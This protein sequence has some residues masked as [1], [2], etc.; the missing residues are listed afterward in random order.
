M[1]PFDTQDTE[2]QEMGSPASK[3]SQSLAESPFIILLC[4]TQGQHALQSPTLGPGEYLVPGLK[5]SLA[6]LEHS[7]TSWLP[8]FPGV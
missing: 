7:V 2:A 4:P 5:V 3:A 8:A 6:H 1:A